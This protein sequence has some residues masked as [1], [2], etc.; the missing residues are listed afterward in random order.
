MHE[1]LHNATGP[2]VQGWRI[3]SRN[4]IAATLLLANFGMPG[5][6]QDRSEQ[7]NT[8]RIT[9][10]AVDGFGSPL[11]TV[12]VDSFVDEKGRDRAARFHG[13]TASGIPFGQYRITLHSDSAFV[14]TTF[15]VDV[16]APHVLITAAFE[17]PG[18]ENVRITGE[19][20]GRLAGFP[21][22]WGDWWCKAAGLYSR[23]EYESAVTP[24][25][26]RFNFGKVPP[27]I[28]VL[29]CAANKKFVA[30]RTV[31]IAADAAPFTIDYKADEDGEAVKH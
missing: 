21:P 1:T 8:A 31:R 20:Q 28:Y 22:T 6:S 12:V 23:L 16:A 5:F 15:G 24:A 2:E 27:G 10:T 13:P 4:R 3:L 14:N 9:V 29:A 17:W 7:I 18:V 26:L 25:D 19:L 11:S 30:L